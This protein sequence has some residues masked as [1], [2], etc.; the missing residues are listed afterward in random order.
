MAH[1]ARNGPFS[2]FEGVDRT[3]S[4][5]DGAGLRL[6]IAGSVPWS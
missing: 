1:V 6:D 5:L 3:L 4:I 2:S